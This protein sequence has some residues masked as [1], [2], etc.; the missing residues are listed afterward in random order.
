MRGHGATGEHRPDT[1]DT[2]AGLAAGWASLIHRW[3]GGSG[4]RPGVQD[5]QDADRAADVVRVGGERPETLGGGRH[6]RGQA[7]ALMGAHELAKRGGEREHDMEVVPSLTS[8]PLDAR[9]RRV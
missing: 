5:G 9:P 1:A 3:G 6:E 7:D 8:G 2:A 4:P